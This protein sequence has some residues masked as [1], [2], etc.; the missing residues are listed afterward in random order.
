MFYVLLGLAI[1]NGFQTANGRGNRYGHGTP[2]NG[3]HQH[4]ICQRAY[5][6]KGAYVGIRRYDTHD[7]P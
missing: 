6:V 7:T 2:E 1:L 5:N 4:F 3:N